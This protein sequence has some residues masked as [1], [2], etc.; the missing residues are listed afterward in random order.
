MFKKFKEKHKIFINKYVQFVQRI[1]VAILLTLIYVIGFEITALVVRIFR[2]SLLRRGGKEAPSYWQDA[3][4]YD[5]LEG[6][7]RQS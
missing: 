1:L 6:S 3:R 5:R 7:Q 4:E 2:P